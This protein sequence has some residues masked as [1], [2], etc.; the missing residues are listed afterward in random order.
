M[1]TIV[2][3]ITHCIGL[4]LRGD[5]FSEHCRRKTIGSK[6]VTVGYS[7][8]KRLGNVRDSC[9]QYRPAQSSSTY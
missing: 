6:R 1:E 7:G 3:S 8:R 5:L 2:K 4:I 9:L